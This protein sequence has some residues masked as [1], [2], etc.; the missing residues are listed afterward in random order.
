MAD[1]RLDSER[2]LLATDRGMRKGG[3]VD[4]RDPEQHSRA[5]QDKGSA[6][7]KQIRRTMGPDRSGT[8]KIIGDK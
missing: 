5:V 1:E 3:D 8:V 6:Q 4:H 2:R 7:L